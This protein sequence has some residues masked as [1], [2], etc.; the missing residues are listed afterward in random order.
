MRIEDQTK[1]AFQG[2]FQEDFGVTPN[3]P[4]PKG[5]GYIELLVDN[6]V[7]LDNDYESFGETFG[8]SFNEDEAGTLK[9][10]A[11]SAYEGAKEFVTSPIDTTK[12]IAADI[13]DSVSRLG[14]ES[15]DGRLK[16]MYGVSHQEA[17]EEQVTRAREAVIGDALTAS[18]LVPAGGIAAT[19][20]KA[21]IPGRVQADIVDSSSSDQKPP[22]NNKKPSQPRVPF[23]GVKPP[24]SDQPNSKFGL[25]GVN[26]LELFELDEFA[27][28]SETDPLGY[29]RNIKIDDLARLKLGELSLQELADNYGVDVSPEIDSYI[30]SRL[31]EASK[32]PE[33]VSYTEKLSRN[34]SF[35]PYEEFDTAAGM[36]PEKKTVFESPIPTVLSG[37]YW[38][39]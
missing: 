6:I 9:N 17:T 30:S 5:K 22:K 24:V 33:F 11:V 28:S 20:A 37:M 23:F 8:K 16:R 31:E 3:A 25:R 14:T 29:A 39:N 27:F 26:D 1:G 34:P 13:Y 19:T 2:A 15:L 12:D 4:A 7:G 36:S 38:P 32:N 35:S 10:M 18:S 21:V